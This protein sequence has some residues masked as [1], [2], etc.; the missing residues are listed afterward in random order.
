[1]N[2]DQDVDVKSP[3]IR[4]DDGVKECGLFHDVTNAERDEEFPPLKTY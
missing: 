4:T 1:M 3:N 2:S